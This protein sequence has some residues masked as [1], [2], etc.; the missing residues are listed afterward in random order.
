M[1]SVIVPIY[2]VEKYINQCVDSIISQTYRDLEIILVDDGSP[3]NCPSIC[4]EYAKQDIRIKVVHKEN[5]GLMS[6]RQA[7]LK[8]ATGD[9]IGF[10]DGD[11][12][13]EPDMYESFAELIEKYNPDMAV[14]E[15]FYSSPNNKDVS[16]QSLNKPFY[17]KS[18]LQSEVYPTMLFTGEYYNFGV[19]PCCWS[20]VFKKGLLEKNL[21]NVTTDIR[22]GEDAA[23]T[24]PCLLEAESV[25]YVNKPLYNY[26]INPE[27]MTNSYDSRLEDTIL[28]PYD[29]LKSCFEK[30]NDRQLMSQLDNY[31]FYLL[32]IMIRNEVSQNNKKGSAEI[33][34]TIGKFVYN[35]EVITV[36]KRLDI[37]SLPFRKKLVA[38]LFQFKSVFLIYLYCLILRRL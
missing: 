18:D 19:N 6:A 34:K 1:I 38:K 8:V 33:R 22:M 16:N 27:S 36:L 7:G 21:Y 2:K 15:F 11:D 30:Y 9:Y 29:I 3:D 23:F 13:I 32:N 26:R 20:K 31:L 4:D 14:C 28:I 24:Y 10:V 25:C 5:R 17:N 35:P 12:W 37:S